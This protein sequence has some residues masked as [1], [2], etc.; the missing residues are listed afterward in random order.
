MSTQSA[1]QST[2]GHKPT[3]DEAAPAA[4]EETADAARATTAKR[5]TA[6]PCAPSKEPNDA[7]HDERN[8]G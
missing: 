6:Q 3:E 7:T 2:T 1:R 8:P 4:H 5:L